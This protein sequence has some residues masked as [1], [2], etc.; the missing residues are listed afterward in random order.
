MRYQVHSIHEAV[1]QRPQAFVI[2]QFILFAIY[3]AVWVL[4]PRTATSVAVVA[5]IILVLAAASLLALAILEHQRR[6]ASLP[7]I[8]PSPDRRAALVAT[9]L[10][11]FVRHP[12][13]T[14]VLAG[15][16]GTALMHGSWVTLALFIVI[17]VFFTVKSRY[18]EGLLKQVY[19][20]YAAYMQRTGRFLPLV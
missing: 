18:E 14:A 5:G 9:G 3:A 8:S 1:M 4:L 12:I 20:G 11:R 6:N 15:V 13:Y 7:N 2:G 19:P 10:Y 17:A 16:L